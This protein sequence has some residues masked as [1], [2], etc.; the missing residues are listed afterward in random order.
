MFGWF[1]PTL[2]WRETEELKH[3]R[4]WKDTGKRGG[5]NSDW[6]VKQMNR[7]ILKKLATFLLR[8]S[9]TSAWNSPCGLDL[10]QWAQGV[11]CFPNKAQQ[12]DYNRPHPVLYVCFGDKNQVL[13]LSGQVLYWLSHW[14]DDEHEFRPK[15][16]ETDYLLQNL[17]KRFLK[18]QT[19]N[20]L[21]LVG[22]T[23]ITTTIA[24]ENSCRQYAR[25]WFY[26]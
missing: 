21:G 14:T 19:V 10:D 5:R 24:V 25:P 22:Y 8:Q 13:I 3:G 20:I 6:N 16:T 15:R 2:F 11:L 7:L 26:V 17:A 23:V 1:P 9:F 12:W 4:R 18:W